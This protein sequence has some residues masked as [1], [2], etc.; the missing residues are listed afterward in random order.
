MTT[1]LVCERKPVQNKVEYA[2]LWKKK[3]SGK[4]EPTAI[5]TVAAVN[6]QI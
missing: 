5:L 3:A 2:N 6:K 1:V 4:F